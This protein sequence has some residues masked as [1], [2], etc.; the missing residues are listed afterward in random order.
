MHCTLTLPDLSTHTCAHKRIA[1]C[2]IF[3]KI[4]SLCVA[5]LLFWCLLAVVE[6]ARLNQFTAKLHLITSI[7][8]KLPHTAHR[9]GV[10]TWWGCR[11]RIVERSAPKWVE[12]RSRVFIGLFWKNSPMRHCAGYD[13]A[14]P[15]GCFSRCVW[16]CYEVRN[17][18]PSCHI[19]SNFCF[20]ISMWDFQCSKS[21]QL[22]L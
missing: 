14:R 16:G 4:P 7:N 10:T 5:S 17:R 11:D 15:V 22:V 8:I 13:T 2:T 6:L 21:E 19:D 12:L 1:Q 3:K 20:W 18:F 9:G